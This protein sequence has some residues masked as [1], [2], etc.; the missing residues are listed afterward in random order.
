MYLLVM[1]DQILCHGGVKALQ[2]VPQTHYCDV[3]LRDLCFLSIND[4]DL[5][6]A[7]AFKIALR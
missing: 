1:R 2:I 5:G 6:G 3:Y 7:K 4:S